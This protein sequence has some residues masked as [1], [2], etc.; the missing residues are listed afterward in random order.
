MWLIALYCIICC[1]YRKE[2]REMELLKRKV[3]LVC[4]CDWFCQMS[5]PRSKRFCVTENIYAI[6]IGRYLILPFI[7]L[8][9]AYCW[10][11]ISTEIILLNNA[12]LANLIR[13]WFV[14]VPYL[15]SFKMQYFRSIKLWRMLL[16][17]KS[18]WI[19]EK[20]HFDRYNGKKCFRWKNG[21]LLLDIFL[22]IE[23]QMKIP[24]GYIF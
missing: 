18:T 8:P 3:K 2:I 16:F 23:L 7:W 11:P 12:F 24:R 13:L 6:N 15:I 10:N 17:T 21:H 14:R 19:L 22:C 9:K 20:S 4:H 5:P 1:I